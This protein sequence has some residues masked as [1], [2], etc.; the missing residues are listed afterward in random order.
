MYRKVLCILGLCIIFLA[1]VSYSAAQKGSDA[2]ASEVLVQIGDKKL[3]M[4]HVKWI[5][6]GIVDDEKDLAKYAMLWLENELLYEEAE[7][8][9]ITAEPRSI[10]IAELQ[11][12]NAHAKELE[13]RLRDAVSLD[14][15]DEKAWAYYKENKETDSAFKT[16]G[17]LAFSHIRTRDIKV[18]KTALKKIKAGQSINELAKELSIYGDAYLGGTAK[19]Y[20]YGVARKRF[21]DNFVEQLLAAK[22]GQIIGPVEIKKGVFEIARLDSNTEPKYRPFEQAKRPIKTKLLLAEKHKAFDAVVESLKAISAERIVLSPKI[23]Q[24]N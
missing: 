7:K 4:Q 16:S 17:R 3:T 20:T 12:K 24:D 8:R 21:G 15:T 18:A 11:R 6:P 9:G 14:V 5:R 1:G 22:Q 10:F 19:G 2:D 23:K 13:A